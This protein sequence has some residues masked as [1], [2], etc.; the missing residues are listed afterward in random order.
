MTSTII[1][2]TRFAQNCSLLVCDQTRQAVVIDPG[3]DIERIL[4]EVQKAGASVEKILIT[5]G[6]LDHASAAGM[7]A[8]RTGATI[9][10]PHE[11]DLF[12]LQ[13]LPAQCL[14]FDFPP[15]EE[16]TPHRWLHHGDTVSFGAQ[17][18]EVVHCPGHTPGHL[19]YFHRSSKLV[20]V[21]D[22]LFRGTI[23]A[24]SHA[25]G[26]RRQLIASIRDRLFPLGDD[27]RF[28]PG[29]GTTSTIGFERE[30]NPFV[31]DYL[32]A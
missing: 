16:F 2:V 18:I 12:L 31:A 15:I 30:I 9:E 27:V 14:E 25:Y 4:A 5:H 28:I 23:G 3:G 26:D 7:L 8:Q 22:I 13:E 24:T 19:A 21:G 29:H 11:G 20:A 1:P 6:H 17:T 10:G 32:F